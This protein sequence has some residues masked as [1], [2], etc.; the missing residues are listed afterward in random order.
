MFIDFVLKILEYLDDL[1]NYYSG[2][3]GNPDGE[4]MGCPIVKDLFNN[5]KYDYFRYLTV[6]YNCTRNNNRNLKNINFC[7]NIVY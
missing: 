7:T 1:R 2:G 5:F 6:H 4:T 3:Y